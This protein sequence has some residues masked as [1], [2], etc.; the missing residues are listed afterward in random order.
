MPSEPARRKRHRLDN[1]VYAQTGTI[2]LLTACTDARRPLFSNPDHADCVVDELRR[3]HSDAWRVFGYCVMPDHV[4]TLVLNAD[5][6]LVDFMRLFKGRTTR[7]LRG[8]VTGTI[9][10]RSF[11]DHL[12][13][14][15][16]DITATLKYML[17]NP[18]RAGLVDDWTQYRWSGS[19]VWPEI[20]P[21]FFE[22]NPK[23]VLWNEIFAL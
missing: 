5:G 14:R 11:H 12:I 18:V 3:L 21:G 1:R 20:D 10:Q 8:R 22:V 4:H 16:E 6:S 17:D 13:R 19:L 15:N 7:N 2:G 9:W 23:D